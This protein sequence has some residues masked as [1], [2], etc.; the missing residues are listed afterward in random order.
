MAEMD[1][2]D[3]IPEVERIEQPFC[4]CVCVCVCVLKSKCVVEM[5]VVA[6]ALSKWPTLK[7]WQKKNRIVT[8]STLLPS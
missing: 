4:V 3:W 8:L 2:E 7:A 5:L 1:V 6:L